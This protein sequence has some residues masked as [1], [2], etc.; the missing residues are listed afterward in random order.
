[1]IYIFFLFLIEH[2]DFEE[3]DDE[4]DDDNKSDDALERLRSNCFFLIIFFSFLLLCDF[5]EYEESDE[6]DDDDDESDDD[7][8]FLCFLDTP[9]FSPFLLLCGCSDEPIEIDICGAKYW[10]CLDCL[11]GSCSIVL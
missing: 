10:S 7:E 4:S 3:S 11:L 1:M 5:E 2:E 8:R 9:P 6:D